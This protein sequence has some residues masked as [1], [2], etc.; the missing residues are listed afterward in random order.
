[1]KLNSSELAMKF[2]HR[3]IKTV[4]LTWV[5]LVAKIA[6]L[7]YVVRVLS[8]CP[9]QYIAFLLR[10]YGAKIGDNC[11]FKDG[12]QIDNAIG[13]KTSTG[14]FSNLIIG[15][16]CYIGKNVFFD[17]PQPIII[18]DECAISAGVKF[19]THADCGQRMM[20]HWYPARRGKIVIG[21]GSWIGVNAVILDSVVLGKCCVVAAGAIVTQ[22]FPDYSVIAG[23]PGRVVKTLPPNSYDVN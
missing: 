5:I 22:S 15:H 3:F 6:G 16:R 7:N 10:W 23:I 12:L 19:I 1:M 11:I 2:I 13:D 20:S 8:F 17:L 9:N 14:D 4:Y 18:E 21:K